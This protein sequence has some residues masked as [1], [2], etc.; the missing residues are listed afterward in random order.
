[1]FIAP[2]VN[3]ASKEHKIKIKQDKID[4]FFDYTIWK[5]I[6]NEYITGVIPS[7]ISKEWIFKE[8][9]KLTDINIDTN[10]IQEDL[11]KLEKQFSDVIDVKGL[12]IT[13]YDKDFENTHHIVL[14][15]IVYY[16]LSKFIS[17][18]YK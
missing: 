13:K 10:K 7:I 18:F 4:E 16:I 17:H 15:D 14:W 12:T 2:H 9:D 5:L 3:N 6:Q 11:M 8:F 1:M